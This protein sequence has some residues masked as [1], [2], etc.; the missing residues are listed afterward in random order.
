MIGLPDYI[1]R[2]P[3]G[4]YRSLNPATKLAIGLAEAVMAFM[5][6]SGTG[7]IVVLLL[8]ATTA[9]VAGVARRLAVVAAATLPLMASIVLINAFLLPGARDVLISVGPLALTGSGLTF[10]LQ[11]AARLLA[12]S[13]ALAVIFLTTDVDDLLS[14]LERRGLGRRASFVVGA[15]LTTVPRTIERAKGIVDSQRARGLDTEGRFWR[16][17]RGVLPLAGP[18]VFGALAEVEEQTMAL[19]ARAFSAPGRRTLLR[20]LPDAPIE[21]SIRRVLLA[22]VALVAVGSVAGVL[23]LP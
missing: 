12:A 13:L 10:G 14:E 17:A 23:H 6:G 7:P 22:M 2:E 15:A 3:T 20:S 19:E 1:T 18:L 16:R 11:V 8:V 5:L 21:R 9:V 4:R